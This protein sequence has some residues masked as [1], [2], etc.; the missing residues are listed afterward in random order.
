MSLIKLISNL[1]IFDDNKQFYKSIHN[2]DVNENRKSVK[3]IAS[4]RIR[5]WKDFGLRF[6][7]L[8]MYINSHKKLHR[9][10]KIRFDRI[11]LLFN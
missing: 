9:S 1:I 6:G 2:P 8:D 7:E 4:I 11:Y 10:I 5:I 3:N